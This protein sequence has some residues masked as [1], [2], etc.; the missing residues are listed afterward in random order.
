ME[1]AAVGADFAFLGLLVIVAVSCFLYT[2]IPALAA[3]PK[4]A[5]STHVL[6]LEIPTPMDAEAPIA[7]I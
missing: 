1:A 5:P 6:A 3:T 7:D 4:Y 2:V